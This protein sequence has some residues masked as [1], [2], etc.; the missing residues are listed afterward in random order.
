MSSLASCPSE[1]AAIA[2]VRICI[3]LRSTTIDRSRRRSPSVTVMLFPA[4]MLHELLRECREPWDRFR[5]LANWSEA[6]NMDFVD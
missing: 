2:L 6:A 4:L 5:L 1:V 3:A